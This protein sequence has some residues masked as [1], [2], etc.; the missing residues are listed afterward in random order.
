M[1]G[2]GAFG[3]AAV[4]AF[5]GAFIRKNLG[6]PRLAWTGVILDAFAVAALAAVIA[7]IGLALQIDYDQPVALIQRKLERLRMVRIRYVQWICIMTALE[8]FP[9]FVV[10][11][12]SF[13]GIDVFRTFDAN[14]IRVNVLFGLAVIPIGYWLI[15][16]FGQG[17]AGYNLNAATDFLAKL[18]QFERKDA[19]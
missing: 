12:K 14:W 5:L 4:I 17:L 16:K 11:M 6:E 2:L 13:F 3:L 9:A 18:E 1:V 10:F 7:Q 15:R 8:W 19:A